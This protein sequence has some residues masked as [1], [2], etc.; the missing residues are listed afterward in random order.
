MGESKS[1]PGQSLNA[2]A[3]LHHAPELSLEKVHGFKESVDN[4]IDTATTLHQMVLATAEQH[5]VPLYSVKEE[6]GAIF[7]DLLEKLQGLFPPPAK[8]PGHRNRKVM[9]KAVL[10]FIDESFSQFAIKL[11]ANKESFKIYSDPLKLHVQTIIVA[12][13]T[14]HY[15]TV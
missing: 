4:V 2:D 12:I 1:E 7:N 15:F 9:V 14:L 6:F 10:D 13:G 11:G 3:L 5:G 8:A